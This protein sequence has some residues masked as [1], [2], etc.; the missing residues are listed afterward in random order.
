MST[1]AIEQ[2]LQKHYSDERLAALLAHCQDGKFGY[3]S[4]CCLTGIPTADH[5]LRGVDADDDT[6]YYKVPHYIASQ[7]WE[8]AERA[9]WQVCS[10]G[11]SDAERRAALI[12][13]VLAEM[14]RRASLISTQVSCDTRDNNAS[15]GSQASQ[16]ETCLAKV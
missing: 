14:D 15:L 6:S 3:I 12:P 1:E 4:C 10:L 9:D 11:D 13:L 8:D 7:H 2:F 5:A 16:T